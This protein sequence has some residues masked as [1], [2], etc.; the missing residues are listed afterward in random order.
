M[1]PCITSCISV[2][3]Y[4]IAT[5]L[6]PIPNKS[7][8]I[9]FLVALIGIAGFNG[10][11]IA[12]MLVIDSI[13]LITFCNIVHGLEIFAE[14]P[15]FFSVEWAQSCVPGTTILTAAIISYFADLKMKWFI[16]DYIQHLQEG[17]LGGPQHHQGSFFMLLSSISYAFHK[18]SILQI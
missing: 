15:N 10:L 6:H 18:I 7:I 14:P 1:I 2:T 9:W 13:E 17:Q 16:D 12:F 5:S 4:K 8:L 11:F 3:R